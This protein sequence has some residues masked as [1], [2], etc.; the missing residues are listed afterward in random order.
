MGHEDHQHD[1][2]EHGLRIRADRTGLSVLA[3]S[4]STVRGP[5]CM[6]LNTR[7]TP[8]ER[9]RPRK[10]VRTVSGVTSGLNGLPERMGRASPRPEA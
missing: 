1:G 5:S 9:W 3:Y 6:G 4:R 2:R 10:N 8:S 7:G